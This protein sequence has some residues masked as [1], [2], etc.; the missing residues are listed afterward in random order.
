[1]NLEAD[2]P[3][4]RVTSE[5]AAIVNNVLDHWKGD[6]HD[7]KPRFP[8]A[9]PA[10]IRLRD[11]KTVKSK[12]YIVCAKMDGTR[13]LL[14]CTKHAIPG[15]GEVNISFMID[16]NLAVFVVENTWA[17]HV[18]SNG[19]SI[20]DGELVGSTFY[21]HDAVIVAGDNMKNKCSYS[22]R[23]NAVSKCVEEAHFPDKGANTYKIKVKKWFPR[24]K[25][26]DLFQ[27]IH[28][29]NI[30]S[31]GIVFY[32]ELE[33]VKYRTQLSLFKWKP[34]GN[35]TV[36]FVVKIYPNVPDKVYLMNWHNRDYRTNCSLP[37]TD[38]KDVKVKDGDVVE[39]TVKLLENSANTRQITT[40]VPL[41]KRTDKPIG[42]SSSTVNQT[43][44][45][46]IENIGESTLVKSLS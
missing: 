12:P 5:T 33:P 41:K 3:G 28:Y 4:F 18:Y 36:D 34:P 38:F 20:F 24:E 19:G 13:Y 7:K 9:Q 21:I 43:I 44:I 35:H 39:F 25:I 10:S 40:F 32:P 29:N 8:G 42:Y 2:T 16:R 30:K 11:F 46:C 31:D 26:N 6:M 27:Y 14:N 17:E 1:M 45:N 22:Y 37:L 23:M 15:T